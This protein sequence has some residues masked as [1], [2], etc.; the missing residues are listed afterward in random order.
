M[1]VYLY[2]IGK[3]DINVYA[4]HGRFE[5]GRVSKNLVFEVVI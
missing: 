3:Y 1:D 4:M 2:G 5:I